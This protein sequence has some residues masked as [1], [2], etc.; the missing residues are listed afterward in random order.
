MQNKMAEGNGLGGFQGPLDLVHGVDAAGVVKMLAGGENLDCV[1]P[2]VGRKFQQPGVQALAQEQMR[3][4]DSQ[5][6]HK[7]S[8]APGR[9]VK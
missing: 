9:W 1:G 3:R 8:P 6:G 4:Q 7:D 5:L 2:G